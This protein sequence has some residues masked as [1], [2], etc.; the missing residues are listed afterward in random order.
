[1][2]IWLRRLGRFLMQMRKPE[3]ERVRVRIEEGELE[4]RQHFED[5]EC[6][7]KLREFHPGPLTLGDISFVPPF[8][9]NERGSQCSRGICEPESVRLN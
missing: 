1:M 5:L 8:S 9:N 7:L 6:Y 2:R 3:G 4:V